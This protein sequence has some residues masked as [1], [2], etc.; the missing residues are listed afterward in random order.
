MMASQD[1]DRARGG[2]A[3][4][5][6]GDQAKPGTEGTGEALCP[7]CHGTGK[8]AGGECVTCG[9]TGRVIEGVGGG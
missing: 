8:L 3:E 2:A 5:N 6:P 7:S 1:T 9:G 4:L